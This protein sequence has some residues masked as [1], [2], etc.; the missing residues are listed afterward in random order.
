MEDYLFN[1]YFREIIDSLIKKYSIDYIN[2]SVSSD[3]KIKSADKI[4]LEK[5]NNETIIQSE[6][7][8]F[9]LL[10]HLEKIIKTN[11][12]NI[13]LTEKKKT[14]ELEQNNKLFMFHY[15]TLFKL[16]KNNI[17]KINRHVLSIINSVL[18]N[19][20]DN[21]NIALVIENAVEY[22]EKN[23]SRT[24]WPSGNDAAA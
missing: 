20:Q 3:I 8:E 18:I 11:F 9:I 21:I 23:E 12:D 13:K 1:R 10:F 4:R 2:I 5:N 7:Y 17:I 6:I 19:F 14:N 16:I 15:F 24:R 22:I